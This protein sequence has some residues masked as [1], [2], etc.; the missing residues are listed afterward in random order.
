MFLR[1]GGAIRFRVSEPRNE[2][3]AV[4]AAFPE[5]WTRASKFRPPVDRADNIYGDR[6]FVRSCFGIESYAEA[7]KN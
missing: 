5:R 7:P 4:R 6:N 2:T 1:R 3:Q